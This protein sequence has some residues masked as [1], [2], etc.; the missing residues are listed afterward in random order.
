MNIQLSTL[1]GTNGFRIDGVDSSDLSGIFVS[2]AGDVNGDGIDDVIVGASLGDAGANYSGESYVVFGFATNT[3]PVITSAA[4]VS[5]AENQTSAIDVETA[6]DLDAEGAGLTYA[7][8]GG[9]DAGL[10]SI[11]ADTGVLTFD[12]APDF[13]APGDA[14]GDNDY[15]VQVTVT[16]SGSLTDVQDLTVSV[17]DA[18]EPPTA[19]PDLAAVLANFAGLDSLSYTIS[20]GKSDRTLLNYSS[21]D[22]SGESTSGCSWTEPE[23]YGPAA[24]WS[25]CSDS[26]GTQTVRREDGALWPLKVGNRKSW[27]FDAQNEDSDPWSSTRACAIEAPEMLTLAAGDHPAYRVHCEDPWVSRTCWRTPSVRLNVYFQR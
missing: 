22:Y 20:D 23:R 26:T 16:D 27:T 11:D 18:D 17:T 14:D 12:A 13:E 3:A 2:G 19:A 21:E 6:D 1:D 15:L 7:L 10:F 5:V 24:T 4:A 25:S 8:T 9:A